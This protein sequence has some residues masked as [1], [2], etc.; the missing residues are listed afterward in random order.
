MYAQDLVRHQT[1]T[2]SLIFVRRLIIP[3]R[4]SKDCLDVFHG[5]AWS[6]FALKRGIDECLKYGRI[7][8]CTPFCLNLRHLI[9]PS[10]FSLW[11]DAQKPRNQSPL[12][13]GNRSKAYKVHTDLENPAFDS[14]RLEQELDISG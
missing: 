12:F 5:V 3:V 1:T 11:I 13:A 2:S 7:S 14:L 6:A 8:A 9:S 4:K 10:C